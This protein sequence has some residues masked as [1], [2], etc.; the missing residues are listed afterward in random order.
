MQMDQIQNGQINVMVLENVIASLALMDTSVTNVKSNCL[1]FQNAHQIGGR[2]YM[3][4]LCTIAS[5]ET[6]VTSAE[7]S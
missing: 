6:N 1:D 3:T 5:T 4:V 7:S 2:L